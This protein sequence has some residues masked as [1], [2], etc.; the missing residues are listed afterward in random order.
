M[1]LNFSSWSGSR[2]LGELNLPDG[3]YKELLN[4]TWSDYRVASEVEDEHSNGGWDAHL[5]RGSWLNVPDY[6][7]VVLE[8][9]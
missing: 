7:V 4:S 2:S 5:N 3:D 1:L 8:R 6:G 9:R